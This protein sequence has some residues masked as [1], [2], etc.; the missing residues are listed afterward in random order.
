MILG[1]RSCKTTADSVSAHVT[2]ILWN[3]C[4][5]KILGI[6][7]TLTPENLPHKKETK[8]KTIKAAINVQQRSIY[9]FVLRDR[10]SFGFMLTPLGNYTAFKKQITKYV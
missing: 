6:L 10:L 4:W 9:D 3:I 5:N 2:G 1:R 8:N 7:L